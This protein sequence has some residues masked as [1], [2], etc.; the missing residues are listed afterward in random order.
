MKC[1]ACRVRMVPHTDLTA[2]VWICPRCEHEEREKTEPR[3]P[4]VITGA[5][6]EIIDAHLRNFPNHEYTS[7]YGRLRELLDELDH[8]LL[9]QQ[10]TASIQHLQQG[11]N[12]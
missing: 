10:L 7:Q 6:A 12:R 4:S 2:T 9:V 8:A 1:P 11:E 3:H 5:M